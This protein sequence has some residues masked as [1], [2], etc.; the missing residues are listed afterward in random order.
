[1]LLLWILTKVLRTFAKVV[2]DYKR[3]TGSEEMKSSER[4]AREGLRF[5]VVAVL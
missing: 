4:V 5:C 1:V 3:E 2:E